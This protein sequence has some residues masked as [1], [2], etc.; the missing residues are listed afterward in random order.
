AH[1]PLNVSAYTAI[2]GV[3]TPVAGTLPVTTAN[4]S[5]SQNT[6]N[7]FLSHQSVTF[8]WE[9]N[10]ADSFAVYVGTNADSLVKVGTVAAKTPTFTDTTLNPNTKYY[11]RIDGKNSNGTTTSTVW[12]FQ[13]A[14]VP[15]I[16]AGDYRST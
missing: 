4:P 11:W 7:V 6:T 13:T 9:G 3:T 12:N 15:V 8:S 5:P 10:Y 14:N 1:S 16:V 2:A